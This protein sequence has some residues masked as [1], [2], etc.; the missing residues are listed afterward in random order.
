MLYMEL[1]SGKA[2]C[3]LENDDKWIWVR[4]YYLNKIGDKD[5]LQKRTRSY[6]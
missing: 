3:H 5:E 6:L 1:I 4:N 2:C